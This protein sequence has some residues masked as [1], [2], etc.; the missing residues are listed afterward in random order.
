VTSRLEMLGKLFQ[1]HRKIH[2]K[3]L[4]AKMMELCL[5][6][7]HPRANMFL[8]FRRWVKNIKYLQGWWRRMSKMLQE[9]REK[10]A[11]RWDKIERCGTSG[12]HE[13]HS[14]GALVDAADFA[15][16]ITFLQHE[17]R[18]RRL[19]ILGSVTMWEQD[20][21]KWA[22]EQEVERKKQ[23]FE[24]AYIDVSLLPLRPSHLPAGH[25]STESAQ[26]PCPESCLGR[27]GDAEILT[28]IKACRANPK[29]GG[30][31][32]IPQKKAKSG[33]EV[34]GKKDGSGEQQCDTPV[35]A[36]LFG[37]AAS[38]DDLERWGVGQSDMPAIGQKPGDDEGEG[39]FP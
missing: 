23:K 32:Q 5:L 34:K 20:S 36:R 30:W 14:S 38:E 35:A 22:A 26:R 8:G 2:C 15:K 10:I 9:V 27:Q 24:R 1:S 3:R 11:K 28:M 12:Y 16:R 13:G 7:W 33:L 37:E 19:F 39:R 17:L 6:K 29:G 18:A 25:L 21:A 4:Q 31:K